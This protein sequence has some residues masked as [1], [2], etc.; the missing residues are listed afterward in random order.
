MVSCQRGRRAAEFAWQSHTH[1]GCRRQQ[2][3]PGNRGAAGLVGA[4]APRSVLLAAP[5]TMAEQRWGRDL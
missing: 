3:G 5:E 4:G 1:F 2:R